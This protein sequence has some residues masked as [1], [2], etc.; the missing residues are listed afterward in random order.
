MPTLHGWHNRQRCLQRYVVLFKPYCGRHPGPCQSK[1][2]LAIFAV[3]SRFR[4]GKAL[5]RISAHFLWGHDAI[6]FAVMTPPVKK[7]THPKKKFD[8]AQTLV[9]FVA[10][11]LWERRDNYILVD[12]LLKLSVG[13][14][15][16]LLV[17]NFLKLPVVIFLK[18][19]VGY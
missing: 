8:S 13:R 17:S 16:K 5:V 10:S 19:L 2:R 14:F 1:E 4:P 18:C 11:N 6:S 7:N 15:S 12:H 3:V 9:Q